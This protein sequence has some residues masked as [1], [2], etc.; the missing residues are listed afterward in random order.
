M[1]PQCFMKYLLNK[2]RGEC[3]HNRW[4]EGMATHAWMPHELLGSIPWKQ[5][6]WGQHGAHVGPTGPRWSPCWPHGPCYLGR[7]PEHLQWLTQS[8][9]GYIPA[10]CPEI[11][12]RKNSDFSDCGQSTKRQ[13]LERCKERVNNN[14]F[15]FGLKDLLLWALIAALS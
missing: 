15:M 10:F 11:I 9:A 14:E 1:R 3:T 2:G 8:T 13:C 7:Y 6:S 4:S 12:L 5:G